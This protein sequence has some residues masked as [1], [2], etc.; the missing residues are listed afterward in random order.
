MG[1]LVVKRWVHVL[2]THP[3]LSIVVSGC[4]APAVPGEP[5]AS[6]TFLVASQRVDALPGLAVPHLGAG[7]N[8]ST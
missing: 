1:L 6:H 7:N 4:E 5:T 8:A 3:N 2:I